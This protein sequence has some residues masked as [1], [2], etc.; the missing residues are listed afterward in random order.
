MK[1]ELMAMMKLNPDDRL[2]CAAF[3]A[4]YNEYSDAVKNKLNDNRGQRYEDVRRILCHAA[5]MLA[6]GMKAEEQKESIA[7]FKADRAQSKHA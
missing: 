4:G 6:P 2:D 5:G 1:L 3:D 7:L